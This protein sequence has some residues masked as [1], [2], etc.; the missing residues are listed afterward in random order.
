MRKSLSSSTLAF[1][2]KSWSIVYI[3]CTIVYFLCTALQGSSGRLQSYIQYLRSP[4]KKHSRVFDR[5]SSSFFRE[6]RTIVCCFSKKHSG[7]KII[8][9]LLFN[10]S[11]IRIQFLNR[12]LETKMALFPEPLFE[13][14]RLGGVKYR[15][16]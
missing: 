14:Q 6:I 4:Y 15:T 7:V 2:V 8:D 10:Q 11:C 13:K 16:G 5:R 1:D 12:R 9:M 3:L